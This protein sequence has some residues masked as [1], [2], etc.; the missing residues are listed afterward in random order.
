V[1]AARKAGLRT[2]ALLSGG[3]FC[4]AELEAAGAVV[5]YPDGA[6]LLTS[7]FPDAL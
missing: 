1:I 2:V 3:A 6:A 7:S 5:V 4:Q